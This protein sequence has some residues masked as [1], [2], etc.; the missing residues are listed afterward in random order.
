MPK[1]PM[2]DKFADRAPKSFG[3]EGP[4]DQ[5]ESPRGSA[6]G[7]DDSGGP[8]APDDAPG[9]PKAPPMDDEAQAVDDMGDILGIGPADRKDFGNALHTYVASCIEKALSE[10]GG[11]PP[12]PGGPPSPPGPPGPPDEEEEE[13]Q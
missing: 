1:P 6:A 4:P 9:L 8:P 3:D 5:E 2:V 12:M 13:P 11:G 7:P 10:A